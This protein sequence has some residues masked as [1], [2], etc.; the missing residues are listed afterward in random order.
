MPSRAATQVRVGRPPVEFTNLDQVLYPRTGFTKRDVVQYYLEVAPVLL[1]HLRSRALTMKRSPEGVEGHFL[2]E[3]NCPAHR[4]DWIHT[5]RVASTRGHGQTQHCMV[6]NVASL[7]WV[8][9]LGDL[10]L[11]VS[12]ART[13]AWHRPTAMV[14]DLDPG[15]GADILDCAQ[16]ALWL[17][18]RLKFLSLESFSKTS[19]NKGLQVYVPLNTP[20]DFGRTSAASRTIAQI[21]ESAHPDRIVTNMRKELRRGKVLIDWSQNQNHKTTLCVYSLRATPSPAVSTPLEW[22]EVASAVRRRDAAA[23]R[24]GP[25]EVLA[26]IRRHGDLFAQLPSLRQK[27]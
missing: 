4:P 16:V 20:A 1:P 24:F 11:H 18:E 21:L 12:L 26:R 15:E 3:K 5:S 27:L 17:Q 19:G 10:E 22:K 13:G 23:L 25:Q 9:H 2:Y 14:F 8:A 6:D 7:A